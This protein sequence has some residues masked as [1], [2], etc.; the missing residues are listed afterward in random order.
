M[1][2][3]VNQTGFEKGAAFGV[4][5]SHK[6]NVK[7][8]FSKK[9]SISVFFL[10]AGCSV[11]SPDF[12]VK[13]MKVESALHS[14]REIQ[15]DEDNEEK[16]DKLSHYVGH[17]RDNHAPG[18][19][20]DQYWKAVNDQALYKNMT[21]REL[22][23]LFS[24]NDVS[25]RPENRDSFASLLLETVKA[26]SQKVSL[27]RPELKRLRTACS[28]SLSD[29]SF[30]SLVWFLARERAKE[31]AG[32]I[33]LAK[34]QALSPAQPES[35]PA[36]SSRPYTYTE[37]LQ[38]VLLE[39][40]QVQSSRAW[41]DILTVV[42]K[43]FWSDVRWLN[44]YQGNTEYLKQTLSLE[45]SAY[46]SISHPEQDLLLLFSEKKALADRMALFGYEKYLSVPGALDWP[47]LTTALLQHYPGPPENGNVKTLVSLFS[48][49]CQARDFPPFSRLMKQWNIA[50][51]P[52]PGFCLSGR[53]SA[54][55]PAG[56]QTGPT[57]PQ[58]PAG[59]HQTSP[60]P[61]SVS[62]ESLQQMF[63]HLPV[64]DSVM[65]LLSLYEKEKHL[66]P[67]AEWESLLTGFSKKDHVEVMALLRE[68][69][70]RQN[71]MR[72]LDMHAQVFR[73]EVPF[74]AEDIFSVMLSEEE[75]IYSM[76]KKGYSPSY[77]NHPHV[78]EHFWRRVQGQEQ[79]N[80][81][82]EMAEW[83]NRSERCD[84]AYV[85]KLYRFFSESG[86]QDLLLEQFRFDRCTQFISEFR[87]TE[88]NKLVVQFRMRGFTPADSADQET[89][90]DSDLIW[91]M[92]RVLSLP[93]SLDLS[94]RG[95]VDKGEEWLIQ[96]FAI[97]YE[98]F[99]EENV[100]VQEAI[101]Q[102]NPYEW[103]EFFKV[104]INSLK[105]PRF[106][107]YEPIFHYV[108]DMSRMVY[109]LSFQ[110]AVCGFFAHRN[111]HKL[112]GQY[113]PS[114][115]WGLF[116]PVDWSQ[117]SH[118]GGRNKKIGSVCSDL[119]SPKRINALLFA[120]SRSIFDGL[121]AKGVPADIYAEQV[122]R[123]ADQLIVL[124][125]RVR[126]FDDRNSTA[127][128][129]RNSLSNLRTLYTGDEY[130]MEKGYISDEALMFY[131]SGLIAQKLQSVAKSDQELKQ[132]LRHYQETGPAPLN[133]FDEVSRERVRDFLALSS[134]NFA[135]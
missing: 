101:S 11:A 122:K 102:L 29:P 5:S 2:F 131:F 69:H 99:M 56:D 94:I 104:M 134:K 65:Y 78:R 125:D 66:R 13:G 63:S 79:E 128:R 16:E 85:R 80:E 83:G 76:M 123:Q 86:K 50:E 90:N 9:I 92:A 36:E 116:H 14:L 54:Q 129:V 64:L 52:D 20:W 127:Y 25:C 46:Q 88:W 87:E 3:V 112:V 39:E 133:P 37:E 124:F 19:A 106:Q 32:Q 110:Q 31:E 10:L 109:P 121:S 130:D 82:E 8:A 74:L 28:A 24:L 98:D 40:W 97:P 42:D 1:I 17:L 71:I 75:S 57:A 84:Y 73:G 49:S 61:S 132:I 120:L 135:K 58:A 30:K 47:S 12:I 34:E 53:T 33:Q 126:P 41:S 91:W 115:I 107:A 15:A 26:D 114:F 103:N 100:S 23:Q 113:H 68:K 6:A 96:M 108:S 51:R 45:W 22:S 70:D 81:P 62:A 60:T 21:E 27:I 35:G 117:F 4:F 119:V 89:Q 72:V 38:A 18:F 59:D 105:S 95:S 93:Y 7:H 48:R 111:S 67:R 118:K 55:A 44:L 77:M 43:A